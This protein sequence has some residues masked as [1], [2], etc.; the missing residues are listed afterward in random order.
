MLYLGP[1]NKFQ[2]RCGCQ[3]AGMQ[4]CDIHSAILNALMDAGFRR[5]FPPLLRFSMQ[6]QIMTCIMDD[7]NACLPMV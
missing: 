2:P 3:H 4:A 1:V 5:E 6:L 7:R